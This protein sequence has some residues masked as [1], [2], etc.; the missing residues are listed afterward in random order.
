[1]RTIIAGSREAFENDTL[2]GIDSCPWKAQINL[3]VSGTARGADYWG[4]RWAE[5]NK[6]PIKRYYP[7]WNRH[8]KSAGPIRNQE[9]AENADALICIWDGKSKGSKN[10]IET[11]EKQ[12]IKIHLHM[13]NQND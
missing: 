9:M 12:G 1:M 11:A 2:A 3:V 4:E 5:E 6:I 7:D 13:I 8:G 10:M